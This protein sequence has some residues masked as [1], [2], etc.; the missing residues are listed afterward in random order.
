[1][2][3]PGRY[4]SRGELLPGIM[5]DH[6]AD[7]V[8]ADADVI[9][10]FARRDATRY[11]QLT[12]IK[13]RHGFRDLSQPLRVELAAWARNEAV[14]FDRWPGASRSAD[15]MDAGWKD[16]HP[17]YQRRRTFSRHGDSFC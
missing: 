11:E 3:F 6:I 14:G 17:W 16:H 12:A 7:Q 4:L 15:R 10:L 2:R 9:A 5:L 8:Q 13:E 1:M